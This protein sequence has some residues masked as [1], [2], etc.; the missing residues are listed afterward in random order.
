M[1]EDSVT[2]T[3]ALTAPSVLDAVLQ[4]GPADLEPQ[5]RVIQIRPDQFTVK[6][7]HYGGYEHFERAANGA[8]PDDLTGGP[9]AFH[10]A[11]RTR[12]AE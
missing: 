10:W 7:E 11:R 9:V 3:S 4:G 5:Q 6:I 1:S 8:T 2:H 12:M